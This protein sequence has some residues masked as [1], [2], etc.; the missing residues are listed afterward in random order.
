M[1]HY[2]TKE[3][4]KA[5]EEFIG[6][7]GSLEKHVIFDQRIR[8]AFEKLIESLIYTYGFY[9]LDDVETLSMDCLTN[10]YEMLPKFDPK[11]GTKGFSYFN[12]V[13]KNWFIQR[14]KE[15]SKGGKLESELYRDIDHEVAKNN[16][17]LLIESFEED[18]QR[19]EFWKEFISQIDHWR[20]LL[21][22]KSERQILDAIGFLMKNS[23]L[24]SI[25]NKKA[26]YVYL[27]EMTGLNQ[28]QVVINL[29]RIRVLYFEWKEQYL[30]GEKKDE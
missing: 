2:F 29:K 4:D 15:R 12:V 14:A 26:I 22:K 27:R 24:V 9:H 3:T 16:P 8:P 23:D 18:L 19:D 25:Y 5:I 30:S 11:K 17:S 20:G 28:K 13:A 10:L 6:C 7:S 21:T 1:A